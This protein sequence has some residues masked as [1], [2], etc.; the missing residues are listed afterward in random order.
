[1]RRLALHLYTVYAILATMRNW[2]LPFLFLF[3]ITQGISIARFRDGD[4][5]SVSGPD[6]QCLPSLARLKRRRRVRVREE[7]DDIQ[8]SFPDAAV[9]QLRRKGIFWQFGVLNEVWDWD[10]YE[11]EGRDLTGKVVVDVGGYIGDSALRFAALGAVV[12]VFEPF[13]NAVS[14]MRRN[15][16]LSGPAGDRVHVHPVA[17]STSDGAACVRFDAEKG[18]FATSETNAVGPDEETIVEVDAGRYLAAAGI[19]R[20]DILKLDCE[21]CEYSLVEKGDLLDV[22]KPAEI[23]MEFHSGSVV[24]VA[25]LKRRGYAVRIRGGGQTGMLFAHRAPSG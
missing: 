9:F 13:R 6:W 21:G 5:V 22:L 1:M 3:R 18:S 15:I 25:E 14:A 10:D 24:L 8:V 17:L 11:L 12:H 23:I 20:S 7:G 19:V 2:W 4:V 16:L